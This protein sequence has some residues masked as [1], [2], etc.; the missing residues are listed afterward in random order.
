MRGRRIQQGPAGIAFWHD[1]SAVADALL[2]TSPGNLHGLLILTGPLV[3]DNRLQGAKD[4]A[5][6]LRR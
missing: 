4:H 1:V 2:R 3:A 6:T 5:A